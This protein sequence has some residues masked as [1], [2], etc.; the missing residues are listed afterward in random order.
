MRVR[1]TARVSL[2]LLATI[3]L[4][5][6]VASGSDCKVVNTWKLAGRGGWDF[7]VLVWEAGR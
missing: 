2:I 1:T 7:V 3:V 5:S 6:V 4:L